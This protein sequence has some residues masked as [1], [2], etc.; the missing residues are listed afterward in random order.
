ME[1]RP[2]FLMH[3]GATVDLFET[4]VELWP[5]HE[6]YLRK[7]LSGHSEGELQRL[8]RLSSHILSLADRKLPQFI[9]SYKWVCGLINEE[10]INFMRTGKYRRTTFVEAAADVYSDKTFMQ[11][12]MEGLLISQ[13]FWENHAKSYLF[14]DA[15]IQGLARGFRYLEIGPGHGLY[16]ATAALNDN[17]AEVEAW[18]ISDESLLQTAASTRRLGIDKPVRLIKRDVFSAE[19]RKQEEPS[20]DVVVISEVLEHLEQPAHVLK[21]LRSFL[22][23]GGRILVN[24]PI[25]SPAPD[26][27]F[28]L[29]SL[30]A[31]EELVKGAGFHIEASQTFPATGYSLKRAMATRTT[32]SCLVI[33]AV[34][35]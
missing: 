7:S 27:I 12:Y 5:E 24:F 35:P 34:A 10:Q 15:F 2:D 21:T 26:H 3:H 25:N 32:V 30:E 22:A 4:A 23:P 33:G 28:L 19:M 18:D 14:H 6:P 11:K 17:C 16:L 29:E 20:F 9:E 31:V 8:D 1:R 13:I